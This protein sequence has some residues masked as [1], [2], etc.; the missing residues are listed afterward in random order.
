MLLRNKNAVIYGAG[1]S[2][3]GAVAA[4]QADARVFLT[5]HRLASVQQTADRIKAAG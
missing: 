3:G 5:G 4:A 1:G 2:L